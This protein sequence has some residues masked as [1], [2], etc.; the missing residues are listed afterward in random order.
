MVSYLYQ[1]ALGCDSLVT[2]KVKTVYFFSEQTVEICSNETY[3]FGNQ[4][5][6]ETGIYFD[7][8]YTVV[9]GC[10]SVIQLNLIVKPACLFKEEATIYGN[11]MYSWQTQNYKNLPEGEHIFS[12]NLTSML[13]CDSIYQLTLN[14][15]AKYETY[16]KDTTCFGVAYTQHGFNITPSVTG[17][18]LDTLTFRAQADCDSIIYLALWVNNTDTTHITDEI[19]FGATYTRYGFNLVANEVTTLYDTLIV[20]NRFGCDS[21]LLLAL[22]VNPDF[23]STYEAAICF[24]ERF[25]RYGFDTLPENIG[26]LQLQLQQ[27]FYS[28]KGCDSVISVTLTVNPIYAENYYDTICQGRSYNRYNFNYVD[29]VFD[30]AGDFHAVQHLQTINGCDSIRTLYLHINPIYTNLYDTLMVCASELP[31]RTGNRILFSPNTYLVNYKTACGCDSTVWLTLRVYPPQTL[32]SA[33]I[34]AG[35]PYQLNGFNIPVD[36]TLTAGYK[37]YVQHLIGIVGGCDSTV[38]LQLTVNQ[39]YQENILTTVC[40][41]ERFNEFGFDT[42][43]T[44][45]GFMEITKNLTTVAGCDSIVTLQLTVN[46]SYLTE[47]TVV[48]CSGA[49]PYQWRGQTY[50]QT[51]NY[52]DL[53]HTTLGCDSLFVLHLTVNNAYYDTVYAVVCSPATYAWRGQTYTQSGTYNDSFTAVNGCDS[54]Y[55]LVLTV[56]P[57]FVNIENVTICNNESYE[58]QNHTYTQSGSYY[59]TLHTVHGC[60]SLF[61]LHLTLRS[62]YLFE[63]EAYSCGGV[64]YSWRGHTLTASGI[65]YDTL[66]TVS[67]CDSIYKLALTVY[68]PMSSLLFA[69]I[70]Q[71]ENYLWNGVEYTQS[72]EYTVTSHDG[73]CDSTAT[74]ILTVNP[75]PHTYLHA[76]ICQGKSYEGYGFTVEQEATAIPRTFT[77][78]QIVP[79]ATCDSI[80]TLVLTI[81]PVSEV[82]I[83]DSVWRGQPY[84]DNGFNLSIYQTQEVGEY[85]YQLTTHNT[86]GCDSVV[87]LTLSVISGTGIEEGDLSSRLTLYPNPTTGELRITNYE[88]REGDNIEIYN[89]LGQKQFSIFNFQFSTIDVSHLSAGMYVVKIGNYVGKFVKK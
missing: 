6:T 5:F 67:G 18:W 30:M 52:S 63:E 59:D 86:T 7:T 87:N 45:A 14:V 41:G 79:T 89:M 76:D 22:T 32:I 83:R 2:L 46:Q 17:L 35:E 27:T 85:H 16:M 72:G 62:A 60:D 10:D 66:N 69:T 34:C 37:E 65:Y 21:V 26:T 57:A 74:L 39:V 3:Y 61:V 53:L 13:G 44:T 54:L 75:I 71:G 43:P 47:D 31:I 25:M 42:L 81:N 51:G 29:T 48:I 28:I 88:L 15:L 84:L 38:I 8:L 19:C 56:N 73:Y 20:Q 64:A 50:T 78:Q 12:E 9:L 68:A 49:T 70:C 1:S 23:R 40:L 24:G 33:T 55:T 11:Q 82:A 36:S 77:L 80:V 4:Y 58:W